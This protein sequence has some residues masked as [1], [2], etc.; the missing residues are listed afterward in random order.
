[1]CTPLIKAC[2]SVCVDASDKVPPFMEAT[3]ARVDVTGVSQSWFCITRILASVRVYVKAEISNLRVR[4]IGFE[5]T[6]LNCKQ[7][8]G[9]L[10]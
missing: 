7:K 9:G 2:V 5:V 6:S 10:V 4:T 1:M 3:D 8:P